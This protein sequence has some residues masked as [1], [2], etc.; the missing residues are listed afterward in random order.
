MSQATIDTPTRGPLNGVDVPTLFA[1]IGAVDGNRELAQFRFR[2]TNRWVSG[3][4]SR[5]TVTTYFGAGADHDHQ[6]EF[7][8]DADHPAVLVGSDKGAVPVEYML[9]GLASCLTAGI[10][11]IA[12]A[13]GVTLTKVESRVEGDIDLQGILGLSDEV[14]NGFQ[15]IRI[16]FDIEGDADEETLRKIVEQ[17]RKRSAVFDVITNPT[18]VEITVNGR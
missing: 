9:M 10:G 7:V 2:A 1:T 16:D 8:I 6:Q 5:N 3:T 14:R 12:S 18:P 11:N 15:N 17:S 13:R 4:H